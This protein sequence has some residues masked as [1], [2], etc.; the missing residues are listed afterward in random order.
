M[1]TEQETDKEDPYC[2]EC[3]LRYHTETSNFCHS[4]R[5][6]LGYSTEDENED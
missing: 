3:G 6:E 1:T 5:E 4:C 2:Q